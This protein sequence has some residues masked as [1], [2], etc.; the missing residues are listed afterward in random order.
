M[1]MYFLQVINNLEK[2]ELKDSGKLQGTSDQKKV[3][4]ARKD[5]IIPAVSVSDIKSDSSQDLSADS[6]SREKSNTE[7]RKLQ[8]LV[9]EEQ[10]KT[11]KIAVD[12]T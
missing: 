2:V 12:D 1:L 11:E 10:L 5:E 7:G 4:F 8:R 6:E 3:S 9:C